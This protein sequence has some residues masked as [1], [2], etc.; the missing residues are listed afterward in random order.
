MKWVVEQ[1]CKDE[2]VF[3]IAGGP[4]L[5]TEVPKSVP[6]KFIGADFRYLQKYGKVI[7]INDSWMLAPNAQVH[8]FYDQPWWNWQLQNNTWAEDPK[9]GMKSRSFAQQIYKGFWV[10]TNPQ[11]E[12]HPQVRTLKITG[13]RGL[14][15]NPSGLRH[16]SNSGYQAINLAYLLGAKKIVLIGYDMKCLGNRTHW[17]NNGKQ[18]AVVFN[19]ALEKSFLPHF[20]SLVE[21]LAKAGVEVINANLDSALTCWPRVSLDEVLNSQLV[22][23][24]D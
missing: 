15:I 9:T 10:T 3:I 22:T 1:T 12:N 23:K 21:P 5:R 2:N 8:Y 6:K 17:H 18:P 16:G 13:E 14:E 20:E 11:F 24:G 7:T 4:S 19:V